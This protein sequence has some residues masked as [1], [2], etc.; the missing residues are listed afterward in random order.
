M[1]KIYVTGIPG[2]GKS[3]L[4]Q[5]L[6]KR[7]VPAFDVD[8]IPGLCQWQDRKTHEWDV[9]REEGMGRAWVEAHE[10]VC[11]PEKM[12]KLLT[13][14]DTIVVLGIPSNQELYLGLF[15]KLFLLQCPERTFLHRLTTRDNE[16]FGKDK[17]EQGHILVWYKKFEERMINAG[18]TPINTEQPIEVVADIICQA[19]T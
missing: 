11:D 17:T 13:K 5:E 14:A 2:S 19:L 16:F 15:D 12:K 18:A 1:S 7:R 4:A 3:T 6:N 10:W 9:Y 8:K